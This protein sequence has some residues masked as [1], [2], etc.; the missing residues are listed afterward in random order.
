VEVDFI[1]AGYTACLQV[2][3][4][5]LYKPFKPYLREENVNWLMNHQEC[6]KPSRADIAK[7]IIRSWERVTISSSINIWDSLRIHRFSQSNNNNWWTVVS[8]WGASTLNK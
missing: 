8:D 1:P 6:Q 4:K 7:W 3:D 5:G 2:M